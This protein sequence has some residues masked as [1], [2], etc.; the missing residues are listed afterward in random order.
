M[1]VMR[2]PVICLGM[3]TLLAPFSNSFAEDRYVFEESS[4]SHESDIE[5]A[6]SFLESVLKQSNSVAKAAVSN[7]H[8]RDNFAE[9]IINSFAL[10]SMGQFALGPHFKELSST[11]FKDFSKLLTQ[12]FLKTYATKEKV[13]LFASVNM[14]SKNIDETYKLSEKKNRIT[15]KGIFQTKSGPTKVEFIVIKVGQNAY[16]IFD[17]K[18]E[19]IGLLSNLRSEIKGLWNNNSTSVKFLEHFEHL[20]HAK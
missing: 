12:Y 13:E 6:R 8:E 11:E 10:K 7:F 4:S 1:N 20:V 3:L 2:L 17:I 9:I 19:G 15:F 14:E 5:K 18:V 16:D